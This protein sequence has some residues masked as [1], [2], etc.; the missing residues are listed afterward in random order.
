[1][2]SLPAAELGDKT[3]RVRRPGELALVVVRIRRAPAIRS[4]DH[5]DPEALVEGNRCS[6]AR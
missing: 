4:L 2:S 5:E 1:M 3:I 6:A